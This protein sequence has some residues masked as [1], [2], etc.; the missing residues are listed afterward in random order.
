MK[1]PILVLIIGP[2]GVGKGA[3]IKEFKRR[4]PKVHHAISATTRL[5]RKNETRK[6]YHFLSEKE[7][8][9]MIKNG[10]F[11]EWGRTHGHANY[12]TVKSEVLPHLE[13]GR[14]VIS[15]IDIA[16]HR[17]LLKHLFFR[18]KNP[19][20][21]LRSIFVK[22]KNEEL[23]IKRIKRRSNIS[24][25]ELERR[26]ISA[27][28]ELKYSEKCDLVVVNYDGQVPNNVGAIEKFINTLLS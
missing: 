13:N 4:N 14:N 11:L 18:G 10:D 28:K 19:K 16:G 7:F 20:Y 5:K 8:S 1:K 2:S 17:T 24:K 6:S 15:E 26:M 3:I 22:P 12:A 21:L 23:L 25:K 27:K 9:R